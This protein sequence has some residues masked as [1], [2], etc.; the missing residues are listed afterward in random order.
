MGLLLLP[1]KVCA[2]RWIG[3]DSFLKIVFDIGRKKRARAVDP[4]TKHQDK[5]ASKAKRT[6]TGNPTDPG[7]GWLLEGV[8]DD[9][10]GNPS[11][12][13]PSLAMEV[14]QPPRRKPRVKHCSAAAVAAAANVACALSMEHEKTHTVPYATFELFSPEERAKYSNTI[15]SVLAKYGNRH[16][17]HIHR[18]LLVDQQILEGESSCAFCAKTFSAPLQ[19]MIM[20]GDQDGL[21]KY[22]EVHTNVDPSELVGGFVCPLHPSTHAVCL[23]CFFTDLSLHV[24]N[25]GLCDEN[26]LLDSIKKWKF[27]PFTCAVCRQEGTLPLHHQQSNAQLPSSLSSTVASSISHADGAILSTQIVM[28]SESQLSA[29]DNEE[30]LAIPIAPE[31]R[32]AHNSVDDDSEDLEGYIMGNVSTQHEDED[33]SS[34]TISIIRPAMDVMV[35]ADNGSDEIEGC[36]FG[37][38]EPENVVGADLDEF[39]RWITASADDN[40]FDPMTGA[41]NS[42]TL[43]DADDFEHLN[44]ANDDTAVCGHSRHRH[45]PKRCY[46]IDMPYICFLLSYLPDHT[47]SG[48]ISEFEKLR[49]AFTSDPQVTPNNAATIKRVLSTHVDFLERFNVL[50][51]LLK[52]GGDE[53][54][55]LS[56]CA[57]PSCCG[58]LIPSLTRHVGQYGYPA[59][60][61]QN[62]EGFVPLALQSATPADNQAVCLYTPCRHATCLLCGDAMAPDIS[63][64]QLSVHHVE[65]SRR[66]LRS[67]HAF[68]HWNLSTWKGLFDSTEFAGGRLRLR[69]QATLEANG[70]F[71]FA[72]I[73]PENP[74][75]VIV[76]GGLPSPKELRDSFCTDAALKKL[77][78]SL[79]EGFALQEFHKFIVRVI[80]ST[81]HRLC[82]YCA[83]DISFDRHLEEIYRQSAF[84][85]ASSE[86]AEYCLPVQ[87]CWQCHTEICL[88]C[89]TEMLPT[90]HCHHH[91]GVAT[92][93]SSRINGVFQAQFSNEAQLSRAQQHRIVE[94]DCDSSTEDI[95]SWLDHSINRARNFHGVLFG[96]ND[97]HIY[98]QSHMECPSLKF[99]LT[100]FKVSSQESANHFN[101]TGSDCKD[102]TALPLLLPESMWLQKASDILQRIRFI[103]VLLRILQTCDSPFIKNWVLPFITD[104]L[105]AGTSDLFSAVMSDQIFLSELCPANSR[106]FPIASN[107]HTGP[108][109]LTKKVITRILDYCR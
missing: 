68:R 5:D 2:P 75:R 29:M 64:A 10:N 81:Q 69:H 46:V 95:V 14:S 109:D 82:P 61:I 63:S 72:S 71:D 48:V 67:E 80:N 88:F 18:A 76:G 3:L 53:N 102:L 33:N 16:G 8:M 56:V 30:H 40:D 105:P 21:I 9:L 7:W 57:G 13:S 77:G 39:A 19:N 99:F 31:L 84:L 11:T 55:F 28:E 66:L 41:A 37:E 89:E 43:F 106:P 1:L 107:S 96:A 60:S 83:S 98:P 73:L 103:V 52:R 38:T 27:T 50:Q 25:E 51:N 92:N 70:G 58:S 35:L 20:M 32:I 24:A 87:R 86:V 47:L 36:K 12:E 93:D 15:V 59:F 17:H 79:Q 65:C 90:S 44:H 94:F 54:I 85:G 101:T 100:A 62:C 4:R 108:V 78:L 97:S 22:H 23:Q 74:E 42:S 104:L 26:L 6:K 45:A 91:G 49:I 34:N